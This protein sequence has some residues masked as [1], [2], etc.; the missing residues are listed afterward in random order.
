MLSLIKVILKRKY[1]PFIL[2]FGIPLTVCA[3]L[4]FFPISAVGNVIYAFLSYL[5]TALI[6]SFVN[7]PYGALNASLTRDN[8]EVSTLTTVRMTEA[9]IGNLMV[10]TFLPLFVQLA[11]PDKQLKDIGM[12]GIKL[13]L[14]DYTSSHAGG[15]F[16]S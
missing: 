1:E 7:I 13:N 10:Y 9:N 3:A 2:Y 16:T 12:F 11:S 6:Y 4:L 14:G 5:A 8:D 15:A